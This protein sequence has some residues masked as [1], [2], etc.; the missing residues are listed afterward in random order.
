MVCTPVIDHEK[1]YLAREAAAVDASIVISSGGLN[2]QNVE[3][4]FTLLRD[5]KGLLEALET[6][7]MFQTPLSVSPSF[8]SF[9]QTQQ[10]AAT[11]TT[12]TNHDIGSNH[13][14]SLDFAFNSLTAHANGTEPSGRDRSQ[15]AP[16]PVLRAGSGGSH[17]KRK[18]SP[19][20]KP[21]LLDK[22][23]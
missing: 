18:P 16:A 19:E 5:D 14:S 15:T 22:R 6:D 8:Q 12:A 1:L 21:G 23:K 7:K 20:R 2:T 17:T 13:M 4:L 9:M 10:P 11:P 3:L